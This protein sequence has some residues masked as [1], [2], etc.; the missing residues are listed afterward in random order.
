[1]EADTSVFLYKQMK[2]MNFYHYPENNLVEK[3]KNIPLFPEVILSSDM[4]LA[5]VEICVFSEL[6][7]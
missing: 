2:I 3:V 1:M 7:N 4:R 5:L 6:V